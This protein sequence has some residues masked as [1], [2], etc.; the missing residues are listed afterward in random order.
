MLLLQC[1][2]LNHQSIPLTSQ[3]VQHHLQLNILE[4]NTLLLTSDELYRLIFGWL[5]A[6]KVRLNN[7][8]HITSLTSQEVELLIL[9][10]QLLDLLLKASTAD[11]I[12]QVLE[13][14]RFLLIPSLGLHQRDLLHL[15]LKDQ[16]TIIGEIDALTLQQS[17]HLLQRS[18]LI[19]DMIIRRPSVM[20][21]PLHGEARARQID[22]FITLAIKI[23]EHT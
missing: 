12:L 10:V 21:R 17:G 22:G 13:E 20:N 14:T 9:Q 16:E 6:F 4:L 8:H 1:P 2:R 23:Q 11:D 15:T 3:F 19:V 5:Q 18:M 7:S